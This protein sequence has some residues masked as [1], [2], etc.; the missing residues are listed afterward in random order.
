MTDTPEEETVTE[1]GFN[2]WGYLD[3]IADMDAEELLTMSL[4]LKKATGERWTA[5]QSQ[6]LG[7]NPLMEVDIKLNA[8]IAGVTH[9]NPA[10]RSRIDALH[11]ALMAD[12]AD[13]AESYLRTQKLT[14][15]AGAEKKLHIPSVNG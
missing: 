13:H 2:A 7:V 11:S 12:A 3:G 9:G 5:L 4:E 8:F 15:G 10:L 14:Q 6:G 1:E